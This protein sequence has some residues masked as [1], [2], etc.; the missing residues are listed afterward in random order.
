MIKFYRRSTS[1]SVQKA[2]WML[3][4]TEQPYEHIQLGGKHGGL[5]DPAY[6]AH[7]MV[8]FEDL[9]GRLAH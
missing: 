5:D 6:Q 2:F 7:V 4:E 1:D 3:G 9:R 8:P